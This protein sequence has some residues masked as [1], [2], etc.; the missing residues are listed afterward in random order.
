MI[1]GIPSKQLITVYTRLYH[2]FSTLEQN[3]VREILQFATLGPPTGG[4]D[5]ANR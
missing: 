2:V 1:F 5:S 4:P 3:K